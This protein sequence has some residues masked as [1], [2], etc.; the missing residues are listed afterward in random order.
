MRLQL[1][2]LDIQIGGMRRRLWRLWVV[3]GLHIWW[4]NRGWHLYWC[5]RPHIVSDEEEGS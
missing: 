3:D 4:G 5:G 2:L 1:G